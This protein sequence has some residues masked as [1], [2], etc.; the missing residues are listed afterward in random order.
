MIR[1]ERS[2][3]E[4]G[5]RML[6]IGLPRYLALRITRGRLDRSGTYNPNQ[7]CVF[8]IVGGKRRP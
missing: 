8:F 3:I 4:P 7:P 6:T 2:V 1:L 5:H